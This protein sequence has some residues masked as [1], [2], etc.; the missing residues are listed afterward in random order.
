MRAGLRNETFSYIEGIIKSY[1]QYDSW[2]KQRE[3]EIFHSH[4]ENDE[5]IGYDKGTNT[6][7]P[8]ERI[9]NK[10]VLDK[11]LASIR[12][13]YSAVKFAF[14]TCSENAEKIIKM[15]Y[16]DRKKTWDG[17]AM[18][19]GVSRRQCINIRDAFVTKVAKFLGKI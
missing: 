12:E 2:I 4:K 9:A 13:E 19:V 6:S 1:N 17:I 3:D 15:F 7:S 18:E 14:E 10:L 5:N 8:T 16:I 11:Q